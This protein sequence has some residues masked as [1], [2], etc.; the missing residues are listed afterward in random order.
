M[1]ATPPIR[2]GSDIPAMCEPGALP[3]RQRLD[4]GPAHLIERFFA[5]DRRSARGDAGPTNGR[6]RLRGD[7][8]GLRHYLYDDGRGISAIAHNAE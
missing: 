1:G 4:A 7:G 8:D 3:P 2:I 6:L 5:E